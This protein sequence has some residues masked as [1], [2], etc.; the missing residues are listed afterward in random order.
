MAPRS[1]CI[2]RHLRLKMDLCE[3][4]WGRPKGQFW[5]C[6]AVVSWCCFSG[7]TTILSMC[8]KP[9][10]HLSVHYSI[11]R[12]STCHSDA[13]SGT[14]GKNRIIKRK[15][16]RDLKFSHCECDDKPKHRVACTLKQQCPKTIPFRSIKKWKTL[17]ISFQ[18]KSTIW[19]KR[20]LVEPPSSFIFQCTTALVVVIVVVKGAEADALVTGPVWHTGLVT[21]R[22]SVSCCASVG[23]KS[24]SVVILQRTRNKN[25]L[26]KF[27]HGMAKR[28]LAHGRHLRHVTR[29]RKR[30]GP[31]IWGIVCYLY[32]F[33][34]NF[35]IPVLGMALVTLK[36][37]QMNP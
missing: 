35:E 6:Q 14:L 25:G 2:S 30:M 23:A 16:K 19:G 32:L 33:I 29:D 17:L 7:N 10:H 20:I 21:A 34:R 1:A 18:N 8:T 5:S 13:P 15:K 24:E 28:M 37:F 12:N 4:H 31:Q 3:Q 9:R 22:Q 36:V 11:H 26:T 27:M